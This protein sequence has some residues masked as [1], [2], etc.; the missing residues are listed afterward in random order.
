MSKIKDELL[1]NEKNILLD[2]IYAERDLLS[3]EDI[4][5]LTHDKRVEEAEQRDLW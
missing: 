1:N 5:Q 4:A 3:D 2:S